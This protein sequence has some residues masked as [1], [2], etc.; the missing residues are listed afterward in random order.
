MRDGEDGGSARE[1]ELR[2]QLEAAQAISHIGSWEWVVDS[3][4]M[5]WSDELCRIYGLEPGSGEIPLDTCMALI[6]PDEREYMRAELQAATHRRGRFSCRAQVVRPDGIVRTIDTIGD[7]VLDERGAVV[8]LEGTSRDVTEL[9]YRDVQLRFYVDVFAHVQ[10]ALSAW[11]LDGSHGGL[12]LV[13]FNAAT[14]RIAGT[15]LAGRD[16]QPIGAILPALADAE[17]LEA[18]RSLGEAQPMC[19]LAA[20]RLGDAPGAPI[21]VASLFALSN[22][23]VGLALEDVTAQ[24]RTQCVQDCERRAL[25]MLAAGSPLAA[26]LA[27]I[28]HGI[29]HVSATTIASIL[30]VDDTGQRVRHGAAPGLPEAFNRAIDGQPIGPAAGA[31]G[32]AMY[33]REPVFAADIE[34]DPLWDA[35]RDLARAHGLRACWSHPIIGN[36]GRV[37][38]SF[39]L[40]RRTVGLPDEPTR[41]LM[42]R[43]AHVVGIVL[44]RR[45][46]DEQ[47]RALAGRIEAAREDERTTIARDIHD[48]L[49]QALT[50]LKLDIGWLHRRIEAPELGSKLE[51]MGR[52]AD[53]LIRSVRRIAA[54]LRPGLLDEL[55]LRAALE[56]QA[57]QFAQRTGTLCHVE[58]ELGATELDRTLATN[59]FRIFQEALT[60]IARHA[61]ATRVDVTLGIE[62]ERVRLDIADDGVGVPDVRPR[63][64][65]LGIVGMR[66]RAL[67][68]G[69]EC[70][71]KRR[72]PA[73]TLVSVVVPLRL[74]TE[75]ERAGGAASS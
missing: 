44:E 32:T 52:S 20:R 56:W 61:N 65:R 11:K 36:D 37:L 39:A 46:L 14:E 24:V 29:E 42:K 33:Q 72:S 63:G 5:T 50:A 54:D 74:S 41:E 3:D 66:E 19:R 2:R 71:V 28:V 23:H 64:T 73:G 69:G 13:A 25:E 26:I 7:T 4:H 48:Q 45:A 1:Q 60:N 58:A 51:D 10:I 27:E 21:V 75:R 43:A 53:E 67:R 35:Y 38:G 40:Y 55:G 59:L 49:G 8:K 47:L 68:M 9:V 16:G 62:G 17:V 30:L 34:H 15:S 70:T 31:C 6:H 22:Q 12:R 18:A 57:E